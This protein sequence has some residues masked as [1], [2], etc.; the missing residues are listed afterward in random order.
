MG[1]L[2]TT[3]FLQE[4]IIKNKIVMLARQ[5]IFLYFI[6]CLIWVINKHIGLAN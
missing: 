6:A 1:K 3:D 2:L 5:G 4:D